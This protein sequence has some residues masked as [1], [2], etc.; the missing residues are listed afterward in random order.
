MLT[1]SISE[2]YGHGRSAS[3]AH[4]GSKGR[5]RPARGVRSIQLTLLAIGAYFCSSCALWAQ[6]P[7]SQDDE[8]NKS[9]T[10]TSESRSKDTDL[11]RTIEGHT[12]SGNR[13]LDKQSLQRRGGDGHFEPYQDI[14][15]ETVQV[16][17]STVRTI[18]RTFDRDA[19]AVKK[20]VQVIEEQKRTSP[21]GE[22][23][24]ERTISDPDING[25]LQ[26]VQ[27]QIEETKKTG[28]NVEET[29][30]TVMLPS[31]DGDLVSGVK[32]QER[33]ERG[34][35]GT[36]ESHKVTLLP[37]GDGNWQV[38][39]IRN[40]TAKQEGDN[41]ITE[42][43]VSLPDSEG[44]IVEVSRTVSKE[45]E[46]ATGEKRNIVETYS[47][48]VTGATP[49]G[50]LH[51]VGRATTN[52]RTSP[53]GQQVSEQKVEQSNPGDPGAGL[54]VTVITT[55]DTMR[56]EPSGAQSTRTVRARNA[57]GSYD[58][59]GVVTV[60]TTKTDKIPAIQVQI[61]PDR[62]K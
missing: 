3:G 4:T 2:R 5:Y 26:L 50:S 57:N 44:R 16:D 21:A 59:Y 40:T 35:N 1:T 62:P 49:D 24:V 17:P 20:L 23:I 55:T 47:V 51:L 37:D 30:T 61:T 36:L 54:Q 45:A 14:E 34:A 39:E 22:S 53:T 60:D 27:R 31:A 42:E 25:N 6:T 15:K 46:V 38:S 18:T 19:D 13:T 32:V 41:R 9:W 58:S 12:Q 8:A 52:Q 29:K 33:R 56:T 43:R 48:S 28:A 7:D 10:A 11:L